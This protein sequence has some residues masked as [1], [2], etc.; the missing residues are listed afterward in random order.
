VTLQNTTGIF[1]ELISNEYKPDALLLDQAIEVYTLYM[2]GESMNGSPSGSNGLNRSLEIIRIMINE[3]GLDIRSVLAFLVYKSVER[4]QMTL[5]QAKEKYG[6]EAAIIAGQVIRINSISTRK[7]AYQSE[8]FRKLL[9]SMA[10]DVRSILIKLAERMYEMRF[11]SEFDAV[12][13]N[14]IAEETAFLYAPVAHRLGLYH[15]KTE[16]EENA[17]QALYPDVYHSIVKKLNESKESRDKYI[18]QFIG[19]LEKMLLENGIH[20][21][22]K[23]RTKS[24]SSIWNKMKNQQV[25][26]DEIFDVFAI[27]II[28][29]STQENEKELCWKVY[30]LVTNLFIPDTRRLRDWISLPKA[31]GYES[32]H[33]TVMG[34]HDKWIE[35]QIRTQRMDE[36]AEKGNAA[37]WKY[38]SKGSGENAELWLGK[39][40]NMLETP[41]Q[42]TFISA[43]DT[44]P[45]SNTIFVFTPEGDLKELR[46]GSSVLDFA[47]DVHSNVGF[48]CS[49]ARV[50][51]K[52]VPIKQVLQ[53]GDYVEIMTSKNQKPKSDWLEF[54]ISPR[55][56][57]KI[58]RALKEEEFKKNEEGKEILK[59]KLNQI[60][61][62]FSDENLKKLMKHFHFKDYLELF[63]SIAILKVDIN[64]AGK[65]FSPPET[66][67]VSGRNILKTVDVPVRYASNK[68]ALEIDTDAGISDFRMAKCC[69]PVFGDQIF[70]FIT[71]GKG[72]KIHRKNCPN[73]SNMISRFDYRIINAR[74][75]KTDGEQGYSTVIRITGQDRTGIMNDI[76]KT[77]SG[78]MKVDMRSLNAGSDSGIF[79][80]TAELKV[81]DI[82][83][84][85]ML[86][87]KIKKIKGIISV[88]R[89][90]I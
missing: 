33:T 8:N 73:A 66:K 16:L 18:A 2:S 37:H 3:V 53:N 55:A 9:F 71:I 14:N 63:H 78:D 50:N 79:Y 28:I 31:S 23:G 70:G 74:W 15:V 89:A 76:T 30:S 24:I 83:H 80:C 40:R 64:E 45:F 48:H 58:K 34:P 38:K 42:D 67:A 6:S 41:G 20:F 1:L 21:K 4:K 87:S 5:E 72:L 27:R 60:K 86:I 51:G 19:P 69:K 35:V 85:E 7:A 54:V 32:L 75:V 47:F 84:L 56:R 81:N 59:K 44:N 57:N 62:E 25:D 22:I 10:G 29:D 17:M 12:A 46:Q 13:A 65:V 82:T 77:V 36:I 11:L 43:Q 88:N 26:L 90:E 39:I 68:D 61:I 52:I 49:G